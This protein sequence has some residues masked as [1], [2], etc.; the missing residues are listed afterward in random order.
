MLRSTKKD[1]ESFRN[2]EFMSLKLP[3]KF[4]QKV[5]PFNISFTIS[6]NLIK[7]KAHVKLQS[8]PFFI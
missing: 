8:L 5:R 7:D 1:A 3:M 2:L 6:I 4:T